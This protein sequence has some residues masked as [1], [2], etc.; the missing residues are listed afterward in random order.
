M[1]KKAERKQSK[2]RLAISG[3]S[4]S[5]KT[6]SALL[7]A[8]GLGGR[9]A[10]LDSERDSAALYA[11]DFDFDVANI[12][13]PY[14]P[15]RYIKAIKEAEAAGFGTLIIDTSTHEWSGIG[16]CLQMVDELA[17]SKFRGNSWSAW[18]EVTPR[19]QAFI[20][21]MLQS[22]MHIIVTMRSKTETAQQEING[23]KTI[24][25]LGMKAEQRDGIEY[26][27]TVVFDLSHDG[28]YAN[29][30]KDRTK[31]FAGDPQP[32]TEETGKLL[33]EWLNSGKVED[34]QPKTTSDSQPSHPSP[35]VTTVSNTSQGDN[36]V[37][38]DT[39][40]ILRSITNA[41]NLNDLK[42]AGAQV[43]QGLSDKEKEPFARAYTKRKAE[44]TPMDDMT[45]DTIINEL[46]Q[47]GSQEHLGSIW[48]QKIEN[49][50][51]VIPEKHMASL[52]DAF[53]STNDVFEQA[54]QQG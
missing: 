48:N 11:N 42:K 20:D 14:T 6:W 28:H 10:V 40:K 25:K 12:A 44:L 22:K 37:H 3:P 50:L 53:F 27:F 33:L 54:K 17:K 16:G 24:T 30:G 34:Q 31:L 18:S 52:N 1:F 8:T 46:Q 21:A 32:I 41:L 29:V 43:P 7:I 49:Y 13:P 5:G 9:I 47:A 23:K 15:E 2:L 45:V 51:G 38:F 26:E 35:S 39:V 36:V 19:H 4:G